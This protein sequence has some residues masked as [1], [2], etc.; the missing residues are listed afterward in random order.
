MAR[1]GTFED[2]RARGGSGPSHLHP[3][4]VELR[5]R[6][7]Q[8][9]RPRGERSVRTTLD[10]RARLF[11]RGSM[12]RTS[13]SRA[14]FP[15]GP[16]HTIRGLPSVHPHRADRDREMDSPSTGTACW[17][18]PR[19]G[20]QMATRGPADAGVTNPVLPHTRTRSR[21][22]RRVLPDQ[23]TTAKHVDRRWRRP[24]IVS[25]LRRRSSTGR[26]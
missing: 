15:R 18:G 25:R 14:V 17:S 3:T 21:M 7:T 16:G 20:Q 19:S 1:A 11:Q 13:S 4:N 10:G 6:S 24:L 2:E 9:R 8:T 12:F 26:G 23:I 22:A 5:P